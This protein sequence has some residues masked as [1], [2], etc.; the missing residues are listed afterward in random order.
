MPSSFALSP[1]S[2]R[3]AAVSRPILALPPEL[4]AE[5]FIHSS[6]PDHNDTYNLPISP[7]PNTP[8]LVFCAVCR[9]WRHI[10][11]TTPSLWGSLLLEENFAYSETGAD[12][13]EFCRTWLSRAGSTPVTLL[14]EAFVAE[15]HILSLLDIIGR[16]S[17]QW[18]D[19]ELVLGD[20]L[21]RKFFVPSEAGFP[22]LEKLA[23]APPLS[24][25]PMSFC[26]APKLR[27]VFL[28]RFTPQ[29]QLPWHQLTKF[30]TYAI[31]IAR[32]LEILRDAPNLVTG[33]FE[34]QD[35]DSPP[36]PQAVLLLT[37]L[38]SLRLGKSEADG[39]DPLPMTVLNCLE[40][41]ALKSLTLAFG[42]AQ[43]EDLDVFPFLS[44][45]ARS[46]F[47]LHALALS[48]LPVTTSTLI[49]CLKATPSVVHLKFQPRHVGV[50]INVLL[51]LL[52]RHPDF[53]PNLQSLS[54]MLPL[55]GVSSMTHATPFLMLDM[56][57]WRWSAVGSARLRFFDLITPY[58]KFMLRDI[59]TKPE[60]QRLVKE[61]M[62]V[63]IRERLPWMSDSLE[64]MKPS[65]GP[66]A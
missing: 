3:S 47:Q 7:N 50:D 40:A 66:W 16:L 41:P 43:D 32:C 9:Q 10:A 28:F 12:Y 36:L 11:L 52:T 64:F 27:E 37:Q 2:L 57:L 13:V 34:I 42:N 8:P 24:E 62:V 55:S 33:I 25:L 45:A 51:L 35:F 65:E 48:R 14:L 1:L 29:V 5:I 63:S 53:L 59:E 21:P 6:D 15:P 19:I 31:G 20:D 49:G 23:I 54:M 61:G 26:K 56:L 30:R 18:R 22:C 44:F 39:V 58:N 4:L 46:S 38:Q 60:C 17:Q